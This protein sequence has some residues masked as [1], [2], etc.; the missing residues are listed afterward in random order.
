MSF[1]QLK[2]AKVW[3]L[4]ATVL[5]IGMIPLIPGTYCSIFSTL[6]AYFLLNN[7][8]LVYRIIIYLFIFLI[9]V[10]ASHKIQKLTKQEDPRFIVID[11]YVGQGV[12]LL[13]ADDRILLYFLG[14]I[15]FRFFDI[16]KP[17]PIAHSERLKYGFGVMMDDLIAGLYSMI[18]IIVIKLLI[19]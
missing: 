7:I 3:A 9:G 12:S 19:Y 14:F 17:F 5:G 10:L 6:V 13:F 2:E 1:K 16:F 18:I 8:S 15:I 4:I 11:E